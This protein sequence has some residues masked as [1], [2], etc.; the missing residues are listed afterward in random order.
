MKILSIGLDDSFLDTGSA[1]A[2]RL[3][4]FGEITEN[5]TVVAPSLATKILFLAINVK[6]IAVG[7]RN[8]ISR[9]VKILFFLFFEL[10]NNHYDLLTIQD[11]YYLALGGWLL[12]RLFSLPIE[13][14][15]HGFEKE[16]FIRKA[17]AKFVLRRSDAV[18][19]V[20]QR[21][22]E[23]L[24]TELMV[25]KEKIYV[26]PIASSVSPLNGKTNYQVI[27][28]FTFVW[29]GRLVPVKNCQLA[30]RAMR[31][32]VDQKLDVRL[33][34]VGDGPER[35]KLINLS[36]SLGLENQ[37][38]FAGQSKD[39]SKFYDVADAFILTSDR[40][41]WGRVVVEAGAKGLPI[42]MTDTGLA[43]EIVIDQ[44]NGL[45]VPVGNL[46]ALTES[47]RAII[48]DETLRR[49]LGESIRNKVTGLPDEQQILALYRQQ[50][51]KIILRP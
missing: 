6:C 14:Q 21:L 42:V 22:K 26:L 39:V 12:A 2:S 50:W 4:N 35:N 10:K 16:S 41:G 33:V 28:I 38:E 19:V 17:I 11:T 44:H 27:E 34:I 20:S 5:Y 13:I 15:V 36:Q 49:C 48:S 30:I 46:T 7:G 45:V 37:I 47:M 51:E 1:L 32:L 31:N 43:G 18:R 23:E 25:L 9:L 29:V 8:K 40:E 24:I 3:R